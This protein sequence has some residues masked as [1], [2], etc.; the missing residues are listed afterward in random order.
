MSRLAAPGSWRMTQWMS[1]TISNWHWCPP[2]PSESYA[3]S[4]G[5]AARL[6]ASNSCPDIA[7]PPHRRAFSRPL[8]IGGRHQSGLQDRGRRFGRSEEL[9]Q[10]VR[11]LGLPDRNSERARKNKHRLDLSR[12]S[13]DEGNSGHMDQFA[14][15]LETDLRLAPR[16]NGG[17]RF[18]GGRPSHPP[19][20]AR[21]LLGDAKPGKQGRRQIGAA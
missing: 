17:Y 1:G 20:R 7:R 21:D 10:R 18:S 5:V 6:T 2:I 16:D 9:E 19:A 11:R 12:N 13:T 4:F 15:L 14:D 8:S 3:K